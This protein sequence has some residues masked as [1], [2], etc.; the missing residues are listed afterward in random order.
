MTD[1]ILVQVPLVVHNL[2]GPDKNV[3]RRKRI[4]TGFLNYAK[5]GIGGFNELNSK[6]YSFLVTEAKKRGLA[7]A[8]YGQDGAV[9]NA[10]VFAGAHLRVKKIMTGGHVGADGVATPNN[11]HDDDRRVGPNRYCLYFDFKIPAISFEGEFD[12]I[13]PVA[14]A[15]TVNKWRL[16]LFKRSIKEAASGVL[17]ANGLIV[18][19]TNSPPFIDLPGVAETPVPR[20]KTKE[21]GNYDQVLK[22]GNKVAVT[23]L[24]SVN[25]ESDHPILLGTVTFYRNAPAGS[26]DLVKPAAPKLPQP[27]AAGVNWKKYGAPVAHPWAKRNATWER[28]HKALWA[29]ITKWQTA[30][31]RR[32]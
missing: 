13:H 26:P 5:G 9:Y 23:G 19:D 2:H 15:F 1:S 16:A 10:S 4:I 20:A 28:R 22:W 14:R 6:D 12:V 8:R 32:L 25:D 27:G 30:Y 21:M 17:H 31:R 3:D 24:H 29:K 7:V 11:P 18:G